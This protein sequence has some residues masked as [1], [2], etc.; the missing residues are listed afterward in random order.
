M[1]ALIIR[2][3]AV[4]TVVQSEAQASYSAVS[5]ADGEV[6]SF[7]LLIDER[8]RKNHRP[9]AREVSVEGKSDN[10]YYLVVPLKNIAQVSQAIEDRRGRG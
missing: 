7:L 2:S 9:Q 3:T 1:E 10:V 4:S 8:L 5:L 6:H